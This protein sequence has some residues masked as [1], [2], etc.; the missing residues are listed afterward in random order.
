MY[1]S[2][3][4]MTITSLKENNKLIQVTNYFTINFPFLNLYQFSLFKKIFASSI[5]F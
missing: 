5:V 3:P 2:N 4:I 1:T